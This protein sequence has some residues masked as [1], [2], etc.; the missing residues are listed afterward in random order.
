MGTPGFE[1]GG[2]KKWKQKLTVALQESKIA[3]ANAMACSLESTA[4]LIKILDLIEA[5]QNQ[6]ALEPEDA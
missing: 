3:T 4:G 1:V 5:A 6:L 2:Y